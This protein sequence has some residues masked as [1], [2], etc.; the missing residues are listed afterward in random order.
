MKTALK[1]EIRLQRKRNPNPP[2]PPTELNAEAIAAIVQ[3]SN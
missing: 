3:K 2:T 1:K